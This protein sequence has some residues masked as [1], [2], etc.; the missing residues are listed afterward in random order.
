MQI[1]C[2]QKK[3]SRYINVDLEIFSD[4]SLEKTFDR[5]AL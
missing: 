2:Q 4:D 5:E 3:I 1:H